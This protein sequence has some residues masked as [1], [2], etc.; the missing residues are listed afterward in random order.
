MVNWLSE[1]FGNSMREYVVFLII[2]FAGIA[3]GKL[4]SWVLQNVIKGIAAK[5]ETNPRKAVL[6][7]IP[8]CQRPASANVDMRG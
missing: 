3:L 4:L 2:I 7:Q 5:T 8:N 6:I 1:L